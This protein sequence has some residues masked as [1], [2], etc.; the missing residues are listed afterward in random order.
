MN[1]SKEMN[2]SYMTVGEVAKKMNIS[3]RT[4]QYYDKEAVLSPSA[5]SEGGR[6][7]Y[8]NK[9]LVSLHQI[10]SLKSLGFSLKEIKNQLIPLDNPI[11]VAA[12]LNNQM[13]VIQKK[14]DELS[15]TLGDMQ[16][17]KEEVLLMK[18]VDFKKIADIVVNL[19][20]K[21]EFYSLIKYFDEDTLDYVRNQFDQKSGQDFTQRFQRLLKK[22]NQL[23]KKQIAPASLEGQS[24]A[25]EFWGMIMEF[26]GGDMQ[27][28]A[29]LVEI[30]NQNTRENQSQ[31][32]ALHYIS[33]ALEIYFEKQSI[34]FHQEGKQ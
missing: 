25:E 19:Q 34:I 4:L 8:T 18:S 24:L 9:D 16:K 10:L 2:P 21:N 5:Y 11:D 32:R 22:G 17:L 20:M 12:V 31:T 15:I 29:K 13:D 1:Q 28:V 30:N 23:H 3:V 7:L 27:L 6:R 26:T 33:D 14:I